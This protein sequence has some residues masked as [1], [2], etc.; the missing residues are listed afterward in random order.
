MFDVEMTPEMF[1]LLGA[2]FGLLMIS[3]ILCSIVSQSCKV[4]DPSKDNE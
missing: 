3:P 2:L 4:E 1:I